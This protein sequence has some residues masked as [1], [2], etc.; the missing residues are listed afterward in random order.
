MGKKLCK[1]KRG[2]IPIDVFK[3]AANSMCAGKPK[4]SAAKQ[5][6]FDQTMF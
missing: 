5:F 2:K 3:Q 4:H 1:T 6:G